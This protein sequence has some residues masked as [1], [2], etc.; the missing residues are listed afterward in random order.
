VEIGSPSHELQCI[1]DRQ[2]DNPMDHNRTTAPP[3][4]P[5]LGA[6]LLAPVQIRAFL[7][8]HRLGVSRASGHSGPS[9]DIPVRAFR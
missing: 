1:L 7:A 9:R 2:K 3:L 4:R 6:L 5:G 8:A